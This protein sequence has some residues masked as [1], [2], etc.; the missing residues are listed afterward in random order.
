MKLNS[1][2]TIFIL[3]G[4]FLLNGCGSL[5][6]DPSS[7]SKI[8]SGVDLSEGSGGVSIYTD[9][10]SP[11][12]FDEK[13]PEVTRGLFISEGIYNL[14]WN[15]GVIAQAENK[16]IKFNI[17]SGYGLAGVF[18]F[19]YAYHGNSNLLEWNWFKL[20]SELKGIKFPYSKK[21]R[22]RILR[23]LDREYPK[24]KFSDLKLAL[25]IPLCKDLKFSKS[26]LDGFVK[27]AIAMTLSTENPET[28]QSCLGVEKSYDYLSSYGLKEI[29]R[30]D[31]LPEEIKLEY[32][33]GFLFGLLGADQEK[34]KEIAGFSKTVWVRYNQSNQQNSV[35][36][37]ESASKLILKGKQ[38][39]L[40]EKYQLEN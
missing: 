1:L 14:A 40:F 16:D 21:W 5:V 3:I 6:S 17:V 2:T 38:F 34:A 27:D 23:F 26:I 22:E 25:I 24:V 4:V 7:E 35:D 19:L 37:L 8:Y 28:N 18:A 33:Q 11:E 31:S 36:D 10:N 9:P 15:I 39:E 13:E 30:M 32:P 20:L 29:W 12:S